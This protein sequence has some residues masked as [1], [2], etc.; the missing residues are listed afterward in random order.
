MRVVPPLAI[1]IMIHYHCYPTQFRDGDFSAPAVNDWL[2]RLVADDMLEVERSDIGPPSR[3]LRAYSI[4][5]RGRVYI[6]GLCNLP[7]PE[8][9]WV[10]PGVAA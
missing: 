10:M 8:Q 3:T 1:Q 5:E 4:T 2:G 6:Q 9:R 7:F